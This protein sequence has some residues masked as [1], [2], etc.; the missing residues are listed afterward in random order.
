MS[1]HVHEQKSRRMELE[2]K[3]HVEKD[4][5]RRLEQLQEK[6]TASPDTSRS[7]CGSV[8]GSTAGSVTI[9]GRKTELSSK[10]QEKKEAVAD[11][12]QVVKDELEALDT[13][14]VFESSWEI[15]EYINKELGLELYTSGLEPSMITLDPSSE[16]DQFKAS[17]GTGITTTSSSCSSASGYS[18][19]GE[20]DSN[21]ANIA[22]KPVKQ[23]THRKRTLSRRSLN[24]TTNSKNPSVVSAPLR[25]TEYLSAVHEATLAVLC[26]ELER[27]GCALN[28][29]MVA[30]L[31]QEY[32]EDASLKRAF[33]ARTEHVQW[34]ESWV[35]RAASKGF[36]YIGRTIAR[37]EGMGAPDW[38]IQRENVDWWYD[39]TVAK[40]SQLGV[41]SNVQK[42]RPRRGS[43]TSSHHQH[44]PSITSRFGL[45]DRFKEL[46]WNYPSRTICTAEIRI[47][48]RQQKSA[49]QDLH[50]SIRSS[51]S[52]ATKNLADEWAEA[53]V[54]LIT[55]HNLLFETLPP[56]WMVGGPKQ[57]D[58]VSA[59]ET[60]AATGADM[61]AINGSLV[62]APFVSNGLGA[63]DEDALFAKMAV[64]MIKTVFPGKLQAFHPS[65]GAFHFVRI[66]FF[67]RLPIC[68][69][70]FFPSFFFFFS[71]F[72][73]LSDVSNDDPSKRVIWF[74][75]QGNVNR[76]VKLAK[77]CRNT[78]IHV[79]V[80]IP[81]SYSVPPSLR[82]TVEAFN[83][84]LESSGPVVES[85]GN[86]ESMTKQDKVIVASQVL[87]K[88]NRYEL[89][90]I[91]GK[92]SGLR[93]FNRLNLIRYM[94]EAPRSVVAS[95]LSLGDLGNY[96][97][98]S[99]NESY[100]GSEIPL[101]V[102]QSNIDQFTYHDSRNA[103]PPP[104]RAQPERFTD[105]FGEES[106]FGDS[107]FGDQASV[108]SSV[109]KH[110]P[111]NNSPFPVEKP[112]VEDTAA[113]AIAALNGTMS[114]FIVTADHPESCAK[115]KKTAELR[116][117]V[118]TDPKQATERLDELVDALMC[119]T[120]QLRTYMENGIRSYDASLSVT[121]FEA[122]LKQ[123]AAEHQAEREYE[124]TVDEADQKRKR[125]IEAAKNEARDRIQQ[126]QA[127]K[128]R[129]QTVMGE[130]LGISETMVHRLPPPEEVAGMDRPSLQSTAHL[131]LSIEHF[132]EQQGNI[133]RHEQTGEAL[134]FC[135]SSLLD[136]S[137]SI[138]D[139]LDDAH[140]R[141][142]PDVPEEEE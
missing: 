30:L 115:P 44:N 100:L 29:E 63:V 110:V 65:R 35:D 54:A 68:F 91:A 89:F 137:M 98:A 122:S 28:E 27:R 84:H 82:T 20:N 24:T 19:Q 69:I 141:K 101:E 138:L 140:R 47:L 71:F 36:P 39:T 97:R 21:A 134:G 52:R 4:N 1:L 118:P 111:N 106:A 49:H 48:Q 114:T 33:K 96:S 104:P 72:L 58:S 99:L 16:N 42:P 7:V 60:V 94:N 121:Q 105:G 46:E 62:D 133:P 129:Y 85:R 55:G 125:A 127:D 139:R 15:C 23:V 93:P 135:N 70:F 80:S 74:V 61:G 103:P 6:L 108:W 132:L 41:V 81:T 18:N 92:T 79:L 109:S 51:H 124:L 59:I 131:I 34:I 37:G 78:G 3:L 10:I 53:Q 50:T 119:H 40:L 130:E 2:K 17:S 142:M 13:E 66:C 73:H 86:M 22:Q 25:S 116:R 56:M 102:L 112:R 14:G 128:Y 32:I 57:D 12:I 87:R 43:T 11:R 75:S 31:A 83:R 95:E 45:N 136:Q 113:R 38:L 123:M 117:W 64:K 88:I 5:L 76:I 26:T 77:L 9:E 126:A 107:E 8:L 120:Q 90:K 67:I